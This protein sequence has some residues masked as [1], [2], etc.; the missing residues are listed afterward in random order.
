MAINRQNTT[1]SVLMSA[2]LIA[3][4]AMPTAVSAQMNPAM[5]QKLDQMLKAHPGADKDTI[6]KNMA[7]VKEDHLVRCYG[8]NAVAKNDCAAGAHSCAGQS[9]KACDPA[10]FVLLPAGDC[11]KIAGGSLKGPM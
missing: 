11:G 7:R 10:A 8:V 2:A 4:A 3:A 6:M 1:M 5:Q 9:T